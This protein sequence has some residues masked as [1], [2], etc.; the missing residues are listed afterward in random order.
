M[1]AAVISDKQLQPDFTNVSFSAN[2]IIKSVVVDEV[3]HN[4]AKSVVTST[5]GG[6]EQAKRTFS[7]TGYCE[8]QSISMT[9]S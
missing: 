1:D 4:G 9:S 8:H 5:S 2:S 3:L 7:P 6:G